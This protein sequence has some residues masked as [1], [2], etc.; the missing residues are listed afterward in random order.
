MAAQRYRGISEAVTAMKNGELSSGELVRHCLEKHQQY[1]EVLNATLC[2]AQ[3]ASEQA[4]QCD[5]EAKQGRFRG[6]LHGIPLIVK[7]NINVKGLP[8]TVASALFAQS[9]PCERDAR[10]IA[11]LREEGAIIL[12]K[13]NMDEF[14]AHVSGRTSHWGPSI[15][16]WRPEERF[17]PGGSSSG[18]AVAV[19]AGFAWGGIGTDTGGSVRLPADWC[20][21]CGLRPTYGSV[22]LDGVYPR[23]SSLDTVGALAR[24]VRD[25][26]LLMEIATEARNAPRAGDTSGNGPRIGILSEIMEDVS[27]ATRFVY[28]RSMERWSGLGVCARISFP[29][30]EDPE[31]AATVDLLRSYEFARDVRRDMEAHPDAE[32]VVHAG[33]LADYRKGKSVTDEAY[34]QALRRKQEFTEAVEA[35]FARE[36]IDALL[37]PVARFTA[38]RLSAQ[39]EEFALARNLVN[40]FSIT[41]GPSLALPGVQANGMP[42][43]LQLVGPRGADSRLLR[44]GMAYETAYEPFPMPL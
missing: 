42:F 6:R 27:P 22:S 36:G 23:A 12:A 37:L 1:N 14:A 9:S 35:L 25:V 15:N 21:L 17:S 8:T 2:L 24:S 44:A 29:L 5:A 3:D 33:V 31:A 19:A 26:A 39:A 18:A 16:P 13:A 10:V 38:P 30:L 7:D 28:S 41:E 34:A 4:A 40:L 32:N 43:G 20:G 11:K